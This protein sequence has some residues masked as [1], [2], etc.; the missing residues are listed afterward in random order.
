ME[1]NK[2][3][4]DHEIIPPENVWS[5]IVHDLDN[6]F[7]LF[8]D[9]LFHAGEAPPENMWSKIAGDLDNE[10]IIFK[11]KLFNAEET[12]PPAAW[13]NIQAILNNN[14]AGKAPVVSLS[15]IL[16]I[17]AAAAVIG[18]LFLTTNYFINT[19]KT[20]TDNHTTAQQTTKPG[21]SVGTE[22]N[23]VQHDVVA[24]QP[25]QPSEKSKSLIASNTGVRKNRIQENNKQINVY[26]DGGSVTTPSLAFVD[27]EQSAATDKYDL[28]SSFSKRVHN[29]KGEIKEDIS[30]LDLP[31]SYF[32]MTGPNGQSIR[33]SSKFRNTIQYLNGSG[34]EEL[35]DV[36][37][38]ESR[39]WKNIFREWKEKVSNSTFVPATN[40]FMDIAELMQLLHQNNTK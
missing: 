7:I 1:W 2:K 25:A 21:E 26:S 23:N 18:I 33:V 22:K 20:I 36:I 32:L 5:K 17:T 40:N 27:A 10:Y 11:D 38:R 24:E 4:Y 6:E 29:L 28:G 37:L 30:L 8:K 14:T 3:I 31:N 15:K 16:K 39:Y 12:P 13:N 19:N 34:N 9:K 35:L